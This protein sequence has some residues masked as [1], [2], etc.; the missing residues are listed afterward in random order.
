MFEA[1]EDFEEP[2]GDSTFIKII[3]E[4]MSLQVPSELAWDSSDCLTRRITKD[5]YGKGIPKVG[6]I[7]GAG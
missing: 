7:D 2:G 5:N 3:V 6:G 4:Q 1:N